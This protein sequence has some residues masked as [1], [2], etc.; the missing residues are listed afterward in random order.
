MTCTVVTTIE[1]FT[2]GLSYEVTRFIKLLM[3]INDI[4]SPVA[5]HV[6]PS[7][8][9]PGKSP[10][11]G[12]LNSNSRTPHP[13]QLYLM[14]HHCHYNTCARNITALVDIYHAKQHLLVLQQQ[15][16]TLHSTAKN[17]SRLIKAQQRKYTFRSLHYK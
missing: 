16:A 9:D 10:H 5:L 12:Y 15:H 6:S 8:R 14:D 7:H 17:Q 3:P 1:E 4:T 11:C 2:V 13:Q